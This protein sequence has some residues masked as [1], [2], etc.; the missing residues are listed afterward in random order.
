MKLRTSLFNGTVLKKD[1]TRFCPVWIIYAV[2]QILPAFGSLSTSFVDVEHYNAYYL[3]IDTGAMASQTFIYA[4]VCALLL[5]GD[6]FKGR[7][8]NA[9]HAF[10]LRRETW[11]ATHAL[12]GVLFFLAPTAVVSLMYLPFL[13]NLWFIAPLWLLAVTVMFLFFFSLAI[14]C[15][16]LTGS[17]FAASV[18]YMIINFFSMLC[19][20]FVDTY[21]A[22]LLPGLHIKNDIFTW[23]CPA[24]MLTNAEYFSF[25]DNFVP[26]KDFPDG[27]IS[28]Q[29]QGFSDGWGYIGIVAALAVA[30]FAVALLLYR[31]RNLESAGNFLVFPKTQPVFLMI[32]AL[33]IGALF[34]SI[35]ALFGTGIISMA[36]GM[37]IGCYAGQML[38]RRTVK[39]FDKRSAIWC[40]VLAG[41]IV[42]TLI[43]TAIDPLG[44]TR[45]TPKADQIKAITISN[46][47]HF[48]TEEEEIDYTYLSSAITITDK[49]DIQALVSIHE[50][51]L[52]QKAYSD[53]ARVFMTGPANPIHLTYHMA[54]GRE[55]VRRYYVTDEAIYQ[56]LKPYFNTPQF[57]LGYQDFESFYNG[58]ATVYLDGEALA[59]REAVRSLLE[60][61]WADCEAGNISQRSHDPG[62]T[63]HHI[64]IDTENFYISLDI[65]DYSENTLKWIKGWE[66]A[67]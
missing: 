45:W 17:R 62:S 37:V 54:D 40:G 44:L 63:D 11:I 18:I 19:F 3:A 64:Q 33:A 49:E 5:F 31:K 39:V 21:Y 4:L 50:S 10:P 9:L 38:L 23:F 26:T 15:I 47:Y 30:F 46:D 20:W 53:E 60:A 16:M 27:I 1:I 24:T 56:R 2:M 52:A 61:V 35:F 41:S 34:Q 12:A 36:I 58:V 29:F 51:I 57:L 65:Y 55:V 22:L 42:V 48:A 6:L 13:G 43:I 67:H 8:C 14:L 59:P 32:F 66:N 28:F 7:L 25:A